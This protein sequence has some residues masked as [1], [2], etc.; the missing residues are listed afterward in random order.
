V[1]EQAEQ[2]WASTSSVNTDEEAINLVQY[3]QMYT[4]NMKVI[5]VAGELFDAVIGSLR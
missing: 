3:Q 5:Q 2:S 4:A 1:R